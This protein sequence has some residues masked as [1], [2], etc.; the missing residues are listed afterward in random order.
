MTA[1]A[2]TAGAFSHE[3]FSWHSINWRKAY[4]IVRRLQARIVKATKE[5]RWNKVKA[6]QRLLTHSRSGKV[7]AVRR[8]TENKGKKTPGVDRVIWDTPQKKAQ[9]VEALQHRGYKALPL[10][11]VYIDKATGTGQRALHIPTMSDQAMQALHLRALAPIV[12]TTG[13][14]NSYGLRSESSTAEAIGQCFVALS[15]ANAAQWIL[16]CDI[17]ACFDHIGHD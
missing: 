6:L 1:V 9:A 17:R 13:D 10:R 5:G 14:P 15:P 3:G 4:R 8:V 12:E 16:K 2:I 11:R 7:L